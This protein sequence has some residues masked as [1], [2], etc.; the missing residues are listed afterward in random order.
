MSDLPIIEGW[1][2]RSLLGIVRSRAPRE[3]VGI[4]CNELV[5]ELRND[6]DFPN[7]NFSVDKQELRKLTETLMIP[8]SEIADRVVL[9]HSHPSG[10]VGPSRFDMQN[11]TPLKHHLVVSLV[12]DDIV[13]TWY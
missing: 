12:E 13:P 3:A 2:K 4:I 7:E 8:T 6:H 1:I 10:G 11:R 9:W 5:Y